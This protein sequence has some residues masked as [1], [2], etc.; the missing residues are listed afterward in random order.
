MKPIRSIMRGVPCNLTHWA[1]INP[2][3][4]AAPATNDGWEVVE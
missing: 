1:P 2:P 4:I 3:S